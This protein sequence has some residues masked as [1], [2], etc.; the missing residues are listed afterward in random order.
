MKKLY[1][2]LENKFLG[3]TVKFEMIVS[4][5]ILNTSY[6]ILDLLEDNSISIG[7]D[8]VFDIKHIKKI[9]FETILKIYY[10]ND[11]IFEISLM[12]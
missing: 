8:S 12:D 7:T 5:D 6:G 4:G 9:E 1:K 10:I 3:E 11:I 2:I